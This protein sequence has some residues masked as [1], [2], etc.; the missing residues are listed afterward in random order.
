[1]KFDLCVRCVF[2]QNVLLYHETSHC[3]TISPVCW[4]FRFA[5]FVKQGY[6]TN[7][8]FSETAL[9]FAFLLFHE[10]EINRSTS[11]R[12]MFRISRNGWELSEKFR[13]IAA[14]ACFS[15]FR[16]TAIHLSSK[17][18]RCSRLLKQQSSITVY[19]FNWF[20]NQVKQTSVFNFLLVP[21]SHI[22]ISLLIN[23][24]KYIYTY[25][26]YM[27]SIY[28]ERERYIVYRYRYI[29]TYMHAVLTENGI[30]KP[31]WF[32]LIHLPFAHRAK[33]SLLFFPLLTKKQTGQNGLL[34]A[35]HLWKNL[36]ATK[37]KWN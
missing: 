15:L 33:G 37:W 34:P 13:K 35:A 6:E 3:F 2:L 9:I 12:E 28:I 8:T 31:R 5:C 1:M 7:K 32:S 16:E 36:L 23:T 27:Y 29:Y 25:I 19:G 14:H 30:W 21:F 24:Y 26:Y 4:T 11:V 20:T 22:Y 18:H 10:T 17:T